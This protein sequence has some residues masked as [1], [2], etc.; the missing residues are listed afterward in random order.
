MDKRQSPSSKGYRI[1]RTHSIEN[2]FDSDN[3]DDEYRTGAHGA[4]MNDYLSDSAEMEPSHTLFTPSPFSGTEIA[5]RF[6][7]NDGRTPES[8][9]RRKRMN[10]SSVERN[11]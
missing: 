8:G 3:G 1:S 9:E 4:D 7:S 2:D 5:K 10:T 6:S 11:K